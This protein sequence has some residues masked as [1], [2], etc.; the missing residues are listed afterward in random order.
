VLAYLGVTERALTDAL[1]Q[2][3]REGTS[4]APGPPRW[5][6]IKAGGRTATVEDPELAA[7]LAALDADE[8]RVVLR[9]GLA[10]SPPPEGPTPA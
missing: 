10:G 2:F 4:D 5:F 8:L 6:E 1:E 9:K 3:P 7:A